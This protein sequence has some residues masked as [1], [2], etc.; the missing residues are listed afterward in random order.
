MNDGP[1]QPKTMPPLRILLADDEA[2]IRKVMTTALVAEGYCVDSAEDGAEA[3]ELLQSNRY[4]LLITDNSMPKVTGLELVKLLRSQ[5][6]TLPIVMATAT[7]IAPT[8]E[9]GLH[10]N[11]GIK[12]IILK[13][14]TIREMLS[15][16]AKVMRGANDDK[17]SQTAAVTEGE[18]DGASQR[19]KP[20][21][22]PFPA[23]P[24]QRILVVDPDLNFRVL[25]ACALTNPGVEV[26]LVEDGATGWEALQTRDY[27]LLITKNDLPNLTGVQLIAKLRAAKMALPVVMAAT[28]L[29]VHDL[30]RNPSLQLAATLVKPF[31][32]DVLRATVKNAG[33]VAGDFGLKPHICVGIS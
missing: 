3:W 9:L 25:Y 32:I 12:A 4:N 26:E 21:E 7:G 1:N 10:T 28:R 20:A 15:T 11:L 22:T 23:N 14:F 16:V 31:P 30:A 13:P 33:S 19:G 24:P 5:N 27:S 6:A 8:E 18:D 2:G 17:V 29:P